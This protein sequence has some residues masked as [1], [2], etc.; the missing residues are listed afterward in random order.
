MTEEKIRTIDE[1]LAVPVGEIT[2]S[3]RARLFGALIDASPVKMLLLANETVV[4]A[5]S[6]PAVNPGAHCTIKERCY[7]PVRAT[8]LLIID[9]ETERVTP[10]ATT[11]ETTMRR[12]LLGRKATERRTVV[13][14]E[15]QR[16]SVPATAWDIHGAF[17][18]ARNLMPFSCEPV[19]ACRPGLFPFAP[20]VIPGRTDV[21]LTVAH[22]FADSVP[23]RALIIGVREEDPQRD[24]NLGR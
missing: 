9:T 22:R 6:H 19:M 5:L 1:L 10:I 18:G 4:L 21:A 20:I 8:G 7:E 3:E 15:R 17:V 2:H 16:I 13:R 14:E 11:T 24:I 12:G 23:F